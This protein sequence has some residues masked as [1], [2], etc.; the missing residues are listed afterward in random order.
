MCTQYRHKL[1]KTDWETWQKVMERNRRAI[2]VAQT[3][4]VISKDWK[5][6][7]NMLCVEI[8]TLEFQN[9]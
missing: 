1:R 4:E 5:P 3:T 2:S 7:T 6:Y 9:I 8:P